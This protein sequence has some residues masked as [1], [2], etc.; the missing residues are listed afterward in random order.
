MES[1]Q[2]YTGVSKRIRKVILGGNFFAKLE[3]EDE[4]TMTIIMDHL[5]E[6][7][8]DI[9]GHAALALTFNDSHQ[10]PRFVVFN[11]VEL[12]NR[13]IKLYEYEDITTDDYLDMM[14][15]GQILITKYKKQIIY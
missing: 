9:H 12:N 11:F 13:E 6:M 5:K 15:D 8:N 10:N 3:G 2:K 1:E 7:K 4:T 14:L